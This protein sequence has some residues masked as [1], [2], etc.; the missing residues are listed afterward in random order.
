MQNLSTKLHY[1]FQ[2]TS[3]DSTYKQD[4]ALDTHHYNSLSLNEIL[5]INYNDFNTILIVK[6]CFRRLLL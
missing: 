5:T 1:P 3:V 6:R 4:Q 2:K